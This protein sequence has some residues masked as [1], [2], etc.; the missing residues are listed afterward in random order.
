MNRLFLFLMTIVLTAPLVSCIIT[1][2]GCKNYNAHEQGYTDGLQGVRSALF[3]KQ[4]HKCTHKY[5]ITLNQKEYDKGF[6]HGLKELCT[7][8]GGYNFGLSG[9]IDRKVCPKNQEPKFLKGYLEGRFKHLEKTVSALK[10]EVSS[11]QSQLP[12]PSCD[13]CCPSC[14]SSS[15]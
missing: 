15:Y 3:K 6:Q 2:K 13:S 5:Q 9:K 11:L 14:D 1:E 4:Q 8:Q 12:C 7:Y 10:G